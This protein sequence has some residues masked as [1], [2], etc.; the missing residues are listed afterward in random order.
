MSLTEMVVDT[1]QVTKITDAATALEGQALQFGPVTNNEQ[2]GKINELDAAIRD[3]ERAT[4]D[5]FKAPK[6]SASDLHS[7]ICTQ[8]KQ[9][10][11]PLARGR[12]LCK[13]LILGWIEDQ[14]KKQEELQRKLEEEALARQKAE[15][16]ATAK[17]LKKEGLVEEA[18]QILEA[19]VAAI[20]VRAPELIPKQMMPVTPKR[21]KAEVVDLAAFIQ[22]IIS[23]KIPKEAVMPNMVFLNKQ[24][25][26]FKTD[27]GYPGV[28]IVEDTT[29]RR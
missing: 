3:R 19:P 12:V 20:T 15:I 7:W 1:K 9:A 13:P 11:A 26:A 2:F 6:K 28:R 24:A 17:I 21:Y 8:E 27:P 5:F 29:I 18:K 14:R 16:K 10:L 23:G 25:Q 22:G 4:V